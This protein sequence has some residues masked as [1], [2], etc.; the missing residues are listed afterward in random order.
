MDVA[1]P[2]S[3]WLEGSLG[4]LGRFGFV[5]TIRGGCHPCGPLMS[6]R[7]WSR[8]PEMLLGLCGLETTLFLPL[9]CLTTGRGGMGVQ[10]ATG[11]KQ[12]FYF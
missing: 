7:V 2:A 4:L 3:S 12:G 5:P 8:G 10:R 9:L 1:E 6:A 11:N